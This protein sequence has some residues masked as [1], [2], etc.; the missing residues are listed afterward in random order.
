LNQAQSYWHDELNRREAEASS[1]RGNEPGSAAVRNHRIT[2]LVLACLFVFQVLKIASNLPAD[3]RG[4]GNYSPFYRTGVMMKAGERHT[5]YD[6]ALQR[7]WAERVLPDNPKMRGDYLYFYHLPYQALFLLPFGFFSYRISLVIWMIAGVG[8]LIWSG[9]ILDSDFPE[10][11]RFTGVPLALIFLAFWPVAE[12]LPEGQDTLFLF[13]LL[14]FS[15]HEFVRRRD[16]ASGG[17]LGLGLFKFQYTIP[18]A[19]ILLF[20]RRPKFVAGAAAMGIVVMLLSWAVVGTSGMRQFVYVLL[21]HNMLPLANPESGWPNLRG[22]VEAFTKSYSPVLTVIAS[23]GLMA[24]CAFGR[25]RNSAEEYAIALTAGVLVSYH[26]HEYDLVL[27]LLPAIVLLERAIRERSW[28]LAFFPLL[29]FFAPL[30]PVLR[31]LEL[32][33]LYAIPAIAMIY[34]LRL[35]PGTAS[36]VRQP[37]IQASLS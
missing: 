35:R 9:Y 30:E 5:L 11:R 20:R 6:P 21:H 3:L 26:M 15:F 13:A 19:V 16:Y 10:L 2:L 36:E 17:I 23:I 1:T 8:A 34:L 27:L 12:T 31:R 29:L 32:W 14:A 28:A 18:M 25:P 7:E 4:A 33:Y 37:E 24:W 22:L